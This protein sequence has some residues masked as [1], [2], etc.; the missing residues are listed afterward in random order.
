MPSKEQRTRKALERSCWQHAQWQGR[1]AALT[2]KAP[3]WSAAMCLQQ[4]TLSESTDR[5]FCMVQIK[6]R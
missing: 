3:I 4:P 5:T 1:E 2:V 6:R